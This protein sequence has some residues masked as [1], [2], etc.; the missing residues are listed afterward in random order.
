ME[1]TRKADAGAGLAERLIQIRDRG[2]PGQE[3]TLT[4]VAAAAEINRVIV[5]GIANGTR[6]ASPEQAE[7]LWRVLDELDQSAS[8]PDT[9]DSHTAPATVYKRAVEIYE[10]TQYQEALGWCRYVQEHRKMGVMIGYAGSGKTTVLKAFCERTSAHYIECWPMML[11]GDLLSEIAGAIGITLTSNAT[12]YQ[13]TKQVRQALEGRTDVTLVFDEAEHLKE[14]KGGVKKIELLRKIW[15]NTCTPIILA[16]TPKL[17]TL[18][19]RGG[20]KDNLAQLYRRKYEF[21]MLGIEAKEV[22][23]ILREYNLTQEAAA[24]LARIA[25][26]IRHGGM[27]AFAEILEMCLEAADGARIDAGI[28]AGAKR[29]KLTY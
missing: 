5:S 6:V 21:E 20:G 9:A 1:A 22:R 4:S 11:A 26:D 23:A 8:V 13:H 14:D 28:L 15:D 16:D 12:V 18:L 10:T 2:K 17:R 24:E 7:R 19:T 3:P 29:Y 27:G 25:T